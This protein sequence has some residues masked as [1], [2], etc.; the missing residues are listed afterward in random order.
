MLVLGGM[1]HC[2]G[3]FA[4]KKN[5]QK[6]LERQGNF[7]RVALRT[8]VSYLAKGKTKPATILKGKTIAGKTIERKRRERSF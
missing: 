6:G 2:Q 7:C 3:L 5:A 4:R 1:I 8:G